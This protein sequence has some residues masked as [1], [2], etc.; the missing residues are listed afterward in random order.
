MSGFKVGQKIGDKCGM[1]ASSTAE[2]IFEGVKIP[3]ENLVGELG[4]RTL[5]DESAC[6]WLTIR[7]R[8]GTDDEE[9][10]DRASHFSSYEPGNCEE[11]AFLEK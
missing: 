4:R 10:G 1:R 2:L 6:C 5:L 7:K 9:S 8:S 11:V 3:R